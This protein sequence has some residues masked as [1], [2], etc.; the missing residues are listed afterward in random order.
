MF[1]ELRGGGVDF[2][3]ERV[4]KQRKVLER[5]RRGRIGSFWEVRGFF[6]NGTEMLWKLLL[7]D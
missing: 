3:G 5:M 4:G 2:I 7:N 1:G 6:N